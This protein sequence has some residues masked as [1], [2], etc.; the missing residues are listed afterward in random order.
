LRHDRIRCVDEHVGAVFEAEADAAEAGLD[1]VE[2]LV[3]ADRDG[4][5]TRRVGRRDG[6]RPRARRTAG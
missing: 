6:R 2:L 1:A 3:D 4:R 5:E